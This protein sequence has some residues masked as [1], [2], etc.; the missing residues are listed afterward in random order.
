[1]QFFEGPPT[2][3]YSLSFSPDGYTLA[4]ALRTG[5]VSIWHLDGSRVDLPVPPSDSPCNAVQHLPDGQVM[6]GN[7]ARVIAIR[8][9]D[10][11]ITNK[12]AGGGGGMVTSLAQVN[13]TTVAIGTGHRA[14]NEPGSCSLWDLATGK[15]RD[16][17]FSEPRGVRSVAAHEASRTIAWSNNDRRVTLWDITRPDPFPIGLMHTCPSIAFHPAGDRIACAMEWGFCILDVRERR[18]RYVVRGHKGLVTCVACSPDGRQLAT[19]SWDETVRLWDVNTGHERAS[20]R[21]PLGKIF[22]LAFAPDGLRLAA[23]GDR[24]GVVVFDMD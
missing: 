3:I 19:G 1:M 24:G 9:D 16:P 11:M 2:T 8:H 22:S 4:G 17:M 23:G 6:A 12:L 13:G 10:G 18:E 14:R 7:G 21:W 5:G 15:R 20:F